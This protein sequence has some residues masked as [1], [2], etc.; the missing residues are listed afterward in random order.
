MSNYQVKNYLE[1]LC[2]YNENFNTHSTVQRKPIEDNGKG[3]H[4]NIKMKKSW[5]RLFL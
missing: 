2:K 5:K 3:F 4:S 1:N